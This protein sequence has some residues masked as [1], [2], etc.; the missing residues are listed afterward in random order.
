MGKEL[1]LE[2]S[3]FEHMNIYKNLKPIFQFTQ[4]FKMIHL[5]IVFTHSKFCYADLNVACFHPKSCW[6]WTGDILSEDQPTS[7]DRN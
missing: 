1:D 7:L 2:S 5:R 3:G 6:S 4:N